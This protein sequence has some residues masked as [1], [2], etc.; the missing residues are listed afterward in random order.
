M[1]TCCVMSKTWSIV[2]TKGTFLKKSHTKK[3][4]DTNNQ[5][6]KRLIPALNPQ[7]L[8]IDTAVTACGIIVRW[9]VK[10][11]RS[12]HTQQVVRAAVPDTRQ[13]I[14]IAKH[15]LR[16][17]HL[18]IIVR[19]CPPYSIHLKRLCVVKNHSTCHDKRFGGLKSFLNLSC[20]YLYTI[21]VNQSSI[22]A[23]MLEFLAYIFKWPIANPRL[24]RPRT[25][26]WDPTLYTSSSE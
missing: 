12:E 18:I 25:K 19:S 9:C 17:R 16:M 8:G 5:T 21:V 1:C 14:T 26:P 6:T 4:L 3:N 7:S 23:T 11:I 22:G 2:N 20:Y 15:I 10:H 13:R 24:N